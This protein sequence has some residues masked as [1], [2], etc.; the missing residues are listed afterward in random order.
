[1]SIIDKAR[2]LRA[3]IEAVAAGWSD[4]TALEYKEFYPQWTFPHTYAIGDRVR[5]VGLLYRCVQAHSSQSDWEPAITPNLWTIVSIEE[6]PEW[7]QPIGASDA[8][9]KGDKVSHN[10]S[11]WISDMDANIWEPGIIGWIEVTE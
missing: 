1:M 6:W 7:V 9:N 8:Y 4:E 11:H 2:W 3:K 5:D 10:G